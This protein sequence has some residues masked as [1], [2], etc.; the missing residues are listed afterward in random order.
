M[1]VGAARHHF[2]DRLAVI[3]L[4]IRERAAA[5]VAEEGIADQFA[6][7]GVVAKEVTVETR[8]VIIPN[9]NP[10]ESGA[11]SRNSLMAVVLAA[12]AWA[13]AL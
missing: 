1:V 10:N 6:V 8:V 12:L 3:D 9:P 11:Y 4:V 13:W 2:E 7:T 5:A